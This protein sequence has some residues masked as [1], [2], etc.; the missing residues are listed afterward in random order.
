MVGKIISLPTSETTTSLFISYKATPKANHE[1]SIQAYVSV[2]RD[3]NE[4]TITAPSFGISDLSRHLS[5]EGVSA[6]DTGLTGRYH[7]PDHQKIPEKVLQTCKQHG[8]VHFGKQHVVR[9]NTDGEIISHDDAVMAVSR[10]MLLERSNWHS[11]SSKAALRLAELDGV[12]FV[13]ALGSDAVPSSISRNVKVIKMSST[14]KTSAA[15]RQAELLQRYPPH[16]VAVI[17]M[18]CKFPGADSPDEFWQLLMKGTSMAMQVPPNRWPEGYSQRGNSAKG[19]FWGN[20]MRDFDSFDHHFFKK[21][22]RE[23][24]SMD[25][26]QRLLL[27]GAN[28]AMESACYF[29]KSPVARARNI[30]C[31]LGL[32]AT[33]YDANVASH[34]PNAFSTL[35]TLRAFLSG[36]I[37]HFFGW[38]GPSVTIDTACSSSAVAIHTACRAL[39][40]GE[41]T[42]ALAGG[43]ALFTSP[44]LY[45]NLSAAH[46]LSPT[47]ATKPFDAQA[48][49][50]CRGEGVGLVVLKELS[51]AV[52]DGDNVL[53][54]IGGSAV[55]QNDNSVPIMVP[56]APSQGTLYHKVLQ[57]AGILPHQVSFVESH[58]TGTP[59]GDPI[60]MESIRSVFG[61]PQ[62]H[63]QLVVSSV[64]GNIGHLEGA[65]G[66]A[67]LIK[68]ILQIEN[69]T[70]ALQAS[71][72]SLNPKIPPLESDCIIIPSSN[73]A[74]SNSFLVACVNNYGAAGSNSAMMIMQ[75]PRTSERT[76]EL[77]SPSK[78]PILIAANSPSSVLEYCR[79]LRDYC[80]QKTDTGHLLGSIAFHL[81]RQ[82][83]QSLPYFFAT[84]TSNM[85]DLQAELTRQLT[86]SVASV[87]QRPSCP[88]L[89]LVFG[90]QVRD[91]VGLSK[92]LWEQSAVLRFHLDHCDEILRSMQK[93]GLY[94]AIFQSEPIADIMTLHLAIFALQY[95]SAKAWIECGL[96]V[97][98]VIGHS[99][100][101]LTALS[102]SGILSLEDGLKFVAGR[103]SLMKTHWG[104]EAGAM[105]VVEADLKTL[106][107][108]PHTLEVACYNGP[109]SHV[110]VGDK[111]SVDEFEESISRK[112]IRSKRLQVT[113]GFHSKFTDHIIRP[114]KEL[115]SGLRFNKPTV[116][117]ETCSEGS[118]WQEITPHLLAE[119]TRSP[120]F[121][122]QAVQRLARSRGL[123][124][125]LEAG[126]DSGVIGMV[127]RVLDMS[128]AAQHG[129]QPMSLSKPLAL[130]TVVDTTTQMWKRGHSLQFWNFHQLQRGHYSKLRLPSY[131]WQKQKHWL[132]LLPP[133]VTPAVASAPPQSV[134]EPEQIPQ[135]VRLVKKDAEG[136]L[137]KIDPRCGEYQQLVSGHV[138][139]GSPLCPATVYIEMA[140]R[141][142]RLL[143]P[144]EPAPLLGFS[145]LRIDSPLGMAVDRDLTMTL[146]PR[147]EHSWGFSVASD[148][149]DTGRSATVSHACGALEL[150]TDAEVVNREFSRYERLTGPEAIEALYQ[151]PNSESIQGSMLYKMFSRVVEYGG[152][153][154]GL[155][156]VAAK[157]SRI[158]GT[159][160]SLPEFIDDT[161]LT[162]P[163]TIDSFMQVSGI[164]ANSIFPCPDEEVYVFTKLD[165]LQFG[166]N[167]APSSAKGSLSSSSW[168]I[169]SN[170][171]SSGNKEL[172]N[173]IFVFDAASKRLAVLILGARLH[174]VRLSSLTKIL[175]RVNDGANGSHNLPAS[176]TN[177]RPPVSTHNSRRASISMLE[178]VVADNSAAN[179]RE[180]VFNDVCVLFERVADVRR[181][182]VEGRMS[183]DDLGIDS[184]MMLEVINELSNHYAIDLPAEDMEC[185]SDVDSLVSYL[186]EKG[187]G[188]KKSLGPSSGTTATIQSSRS[189]ISAMSSTNSSSV[190]TP[191]GSEVSHQ[192]EQLAKLLQEHLEL[193]SAPSLDANLADLGLDSLLAI[194]LGSDIEKLLAVSVDL[195]QLDETSTFRDLVRLAEVDSS[196][197][198]GTTGAAAPGQASPDKTQ[199]AA[200]SEHESRHEP[201]TP[202]PVVQAVDLP[203]RRE[204]FDEIRFD[205]DKFSQEEGFTDFWRTV[206]PDQECLVLS[207]TADA[208][209]KL[210]GDLASIPAGHT[211]P[212]LSILPKHEHLLERMH[213]ILADGGYIH[214]QQS[215]GYRRTSKPF[216]LNYPQAVLKEIISKF[217]L[218][219]SEH[220]LLDVTASRLAECLTGKVDP[221]ALLFA[222]KTN[223]Q[224]L[225]NVYDLAPMCRA[226]TRLLASFIA[227]AFPLNHNGEIFHFLEVGGG[228]G[229][230][231][232]SSFPPISTVVYGLDLYRLILTCDLTGGT[233]KFLVEYLTQC[234]IPFTYTFTDVSSA[235]VGAAKK[236]LAAHDRMRYDVLDVEGSLRPDFAAKFHAIISTNC[237]HATR[238]ATS[239]LANLRSML[240]PDGLLA[241]VE[242]TNGLY[243]FDLVYGLLDGWWL[244]S[245]GRRHALGDISFWERS[246]LAAGYNYASWTDG[247]TRESQTLRL[248]CGFNSTTASAGGAQKSNLSKRAGVPIETVVWKQIEGLELCADIYYPPPETGNKAAIKRPI[249][250]RH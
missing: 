4:A 87:Q 207:Y 161:S 127:R 248:I 209:K 80:Q 131:Q 150:H 25:P 10:D 98:V 55:N 76:P 230:L 156:S 134:A 122:S 121:F 1:V 60:E 146:H 82:Q 92:Q 178:P 225:A 208:F 105:I 141:A 30:G 231:S 211:L 143:F 38:V 215:S 186:L 118:S 220:R 184:L 19:R 183:V 28:E 45:E 138:V 162:H 233:T 93:P 193:A 17:G 33:D 54:V 70:A 71:F 214:G 115:A 197:A 7:T 188:P 96:V 53:A 172:A 132:E 42:Q 99:L 216:D 27:Q 9:S 194:E 221:L 245:D 189:S 128:E 102:V 91:Y 56:N 203:D 240:R 52:A 151:D 232:K 108:L 246:L 113:N 182:N 73:L 119:H 217:P 242:F 63:S 177:H 179:G 133:S 24:A 18:S 176:Q 152:P 175:S 147:S 65:S 36:K 125:W 126:S 95:A 180:S 185:L 243:W 166:P 195:Y 79:A 32:C 228:T 149:K 68:A 114:L 239:S 202:Q 171:A 85:P 88:G 35:G 15:P 160:V 218:H 196:F 74:L 139:A 40:A 2:I 129:F 117:I 237:I 238:N 31:Y 210:G 48:D 77:L 13:L 236:S 227:R 6:L 59:V 67:G 201:H 3:A 57:Q 130:D 106:S 153:Y 192:H 198:S 110:L 78:Y 12:P 241:L 29:S 223:R 154:R 11:V 37:S 101:Q 41:C 169:F 219:T 249:G 200:H 107:S 222:N 140:A 136:A 20:F 212:K 234:G 174:N 43:I 51:T 167:F 103:A 191:N 100:G 84:A 247:K 250:K 137:F 39:Q 155:K 213:K 72:Q 109:S 46:F 69:R 235:L 97:D 123:C 61:G 8:S 66:V 83:N 158:A 144:K 5:N 81:A 170:L 112:G 159:V 50:Y 75:P 165:R 90:G 86:K 47:G 64:K 148:T 62:R 164:H 34:A 163:P 49:G 116:P 190:P 181:D 229:K 16:A 89:V 224:L 135:L 111:A 187:C 173:D 124:T 14:R 205:F 104:P 206:Y 21:S 168:I 58:G 226:T 157:N 120:V 94:P 26:Q 204:I 244:F 145:D 142:C 199:A 44:Y 23:A 22:S